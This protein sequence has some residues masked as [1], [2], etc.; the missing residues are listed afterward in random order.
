VLAEFPTQVFIP[1]DDDK[2]PV[3]GYLKMPEADPKIENQVAH[4]V[5]FTPAERSSIPS[6]P[7]SKVL[8]W[9]MG[10]WL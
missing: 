6:L 1:P 4:S 5:S 10:K 3:S 8:D 2:G 9:V 7:V